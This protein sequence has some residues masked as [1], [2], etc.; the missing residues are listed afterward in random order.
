ML[1]VT[2]SELYDQGVICEGIILKPNMVVSGQD[3]KKKAD[4]EEVARKTVATLRRSVP[5]AVP[6]IMFLSGGQ[7]E[8][9]AT[10]HLNIMNA[11][12]PGQPWKLSF[13]FG[14]ALQ[15]S[16]LNAWRGE[17]KNIAIAQEAFLRRARENSLACAGKLP[18]NAN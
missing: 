18:L 16:A 15:Q 9:L 4:I 7:S 17:K 6:G 2:F 5:S 11:I 3:S 1:R 10:A 14:R 13:S 12:F 8:E